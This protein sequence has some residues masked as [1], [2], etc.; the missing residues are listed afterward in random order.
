MQFLLTSFLLAIY[1]KTSGV[2]S[3]NQCWRPS[4]TREI[5]SALSDSCPSGY[6]KSGLLCYEPCKSGYNNVAGVCWEKCESG[7]TDIGALCA[8]NGKNF[9]SVNFNSYNFL[10]KKLFQRIL[11]VLDA[12]VLFLVKNAV[13]KIAIQVI[14]DIHAHA[15]E[16]LTFMLKSLML[17]LLQHC[18]VPMVSIK[19]VSFVMN[20]AKR[21]LMPNRQFV[22]KNARE[23]W[24]R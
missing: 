21:A 12:A 11:T 7:Y 15:H 8:R 14:I 23:L 6:T 24:I 22:G 18:H 19:L 16:T 5:K 2:L 9:K 3:S 17:Y 4:Y 1:L 20:H 10:H 13:A